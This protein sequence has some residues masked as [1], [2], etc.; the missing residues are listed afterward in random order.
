MPKRVDHRAR[1]AQIADALTRLAA[2]RGL[3]AVSL[4][5]VAAEAGVSAGMVQHYFRSKDEMMAFAMGTVAENV[6]ARLAEEGA[7]AP[8]APPRDAVGALLRQLL[9]LDGPRLAEG[10]VA[11][12]FHAYAAV[13]PDAA[14]PLHR[15]GDRLRAFIADR[16]RAARAEGTAPPGIAEPAAA[17]G[18]AALVEGLALH[19]LTGQTA[20]G[21]AAAVLDAHLDALFGPPPAGA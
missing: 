1:R 12:A 5:H 18:L 6:E 8:D 4:R 21:E 10:R 17:A 19:A 20:P 13:R 3:E 7:P 2:E 9:P 11:L 16:L 14:G 15:G